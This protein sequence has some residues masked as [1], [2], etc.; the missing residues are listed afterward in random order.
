MYKGKNNI[1]AIGWFEGNGK[2]LIYVRYFKVALYCQIFLTGYVVYLTTN[3][4]IKT[5]ENECYFWKVLY[6]I[7]RT[8]LLTNICF[9]EQQENVFEL[10]IACYTR[11]FAKRKNL[12]TLMNI[13]IKRV[14][15]LELINGRVSVFYNTRNKKNDFTEI[16]SHYV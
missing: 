15:T 12:K 11:V 7:F 4:I 10:K 2:N 1:G 8:T 13:T 14:E 16:Y 5:T 9:K 6:V 3:T